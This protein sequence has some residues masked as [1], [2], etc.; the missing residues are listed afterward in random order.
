MLIL[1]LIIPFPAYACLVESTPLTLEITSVYPNPLDGESE[2]VKIKNTGEDEVDLH[3]Y[4]LE[5][6]T[7]KK[8]ELTGKLSSG[9]SIQINDLIF[10]LNNN[11]DELSLMTLDGQLVDVFNYDSS[12]AGEILTITEDKSTD[13]EEEKK[14]STVEAESLKEEEKS[15]IKPEKFPQFSEA[16]PNPEGSDATEEWIELFNPYSES[17]SLETLKLDDQEGG[18]SPYALS[19]SMEGYSYLLISIED[20]NITLNNSTDEIR[21]LWEDEI[22]WSVSYNEVQEGLSYSWINESY[23]WTKA[24]PGE[25]NKSDEIQGQLSDDIEISEIYPDPKGSDTTEEWIEITNGGDEIVD[26]GNWTIDDGPKGSEPYLIPE[27]TIINPGESIV[28]ERADTGIALNNSRDSVRLSDFTG[29]IID[30]ISYESTQEGQSYAKIELEEAKNL[31]ASTNFMGLRSKTIWEWTD[32]SPGTANPKWKEFI[33]TVKSFE[34]GRLTILQGE[35]E[36]S[37][38]VNNNEFGNLFFQSGNTLLLQAKINNSNT[39]TLIR[40]E[41][42]EQVQSASSSF[43]WSWLLIFILGSGTMIYEWRKY[44]QNKMI[45]TQ[46]KLT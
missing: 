45:F 7:G 39:Y 9:E 1:S 20:S 13:D 8:M 30:E 3:Y 33:G 24:T 23:E 21:L 44:Q 40:A 28:L 26:L 36:I 10:Q 4:T 43:P 25:A 34:E 14:D 41:I 11:S 16:L 32:P 37:F 18:S 46:P 27:G 29:E 6:A 17:I 42:L 38:E 15:T 5:D 31:Q 19:G 22:L 2:W 12:I 35:R